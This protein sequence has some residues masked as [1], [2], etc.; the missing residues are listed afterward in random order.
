MP[1]GV[2]R[3]HDEFI[4]L[5]IERNSNSNNIEIVGRYETN[6]TPIA[7]I[8]R[9]CGHHWSPTPKS[10]LNNHGCPECSGNVKMSHEEFISA[11]NKYNPNATTIK[12]LG[13]YQSMNPKIKCRCLVCSWEW[14]A[15]CG[16]LI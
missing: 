6:N 4:R 14:D 5:F 13:T 2:K 16:G 1:S 9:I 8:C 11:F 10:L 7:C 15:P 3:T 12:L